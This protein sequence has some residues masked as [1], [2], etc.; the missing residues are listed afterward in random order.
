MVERVIIPTTL[1]HRRGTDNWSNK[2][3]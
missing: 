1:L 2:K 3:I